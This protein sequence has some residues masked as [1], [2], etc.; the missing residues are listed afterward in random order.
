MK[1]SVVILLLSLFYF[2][3]VFLTLNRHSRTGIQNYHSEIWA[4]KAGYYIYLPSFFIYNFDGK[5]LPKKIDTFTGNG[6]V[7]EKNIVKTK[8]TYGVALLES[9]FFILAHGISTKLG[10][11]NNGFSIIYHK[12]IDIAAVTYSFFG[13]IFLYL[14][15]IRYVTK[16]I[17][18]ITVACVY[19]GTNLFYYS[20]F[21]TGMSHVYSFFLFTC[22]FF[23][24]HYILKPTSG[25]IYSVLF[26]CVVGL[27]IVVRPINVLIFP[28]FFLFNKFEF[29]AYKA[30][31]K[32]LLVIVFTATIVLIPQ[33]I[34]WNYSMGNFFAD[35][36]EKEGFVNWYSPKI[37]NLLCSTNNGLFIYSPMAIFMLLGVCIC[38]NFSWI[39][40][41]LIWGYFLLL[42]LVFASWHA[43]DYGCSYG[44]R[45]YVE[46]F[47]ILALPL[48]FFIETIRS[49]NFHNFIVGFIILLFIA[50]NQKIIFTYDGCW[51]GETWDW[52][53]LWRLI[54][55]KTK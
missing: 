11:Q 17:A 22:F 25:F 16:S 13:L 5:K 14:F 36:Y 43:W 47:S 24:Q 41:F 9:P 45:P 29:K 38:K 23:L 8:Y 1:K 33:L 53:A 37:L 40:K 54:T 19:L 27:I 6:F 51:Q 39:Q 4:D 44:C 31:F 32:S 2:F 52:N 15:L 7:I 28:A 42:T 50:Y 12:M 48:A 18:T 30:K 55:N 21:E 20:I 10:F 26:G 49:F 46:Y 3:T 35:S 34:Y